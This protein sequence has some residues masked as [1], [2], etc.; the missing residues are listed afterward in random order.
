MPK[1]EGNDRII[2]S[3]IFGFFSAAAIEEAVQQHANYKKDEDHKQRAWQDSGGDKA[4]KTHTEG[5]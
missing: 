1:E 5:S 3:Q 2:N 4:E